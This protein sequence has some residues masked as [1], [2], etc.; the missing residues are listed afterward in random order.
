[1][2]DNGLYEDINGNKKGD[3]ND[4]VIYDDNQNWIVENV[5]IVYFDYNKNNLIDFDDVIKLYSTV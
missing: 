5:P 1:M 2:N 3:F 4:V